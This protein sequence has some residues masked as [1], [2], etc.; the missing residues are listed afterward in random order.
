MR[1]HG[2]KAKSSTQNA[3]LVILHTYTYNHESGSIVFM[4]C[5]IVYCSHIF[6][7][8]VR[9]WGLFPHIVT[10]VRHAFLKEREWKENWKTDFTQN[11]N[12]I[13]SQQ[14]AGYILWQQDPICVRLTR[15]IYHYGCCHG[16][17]HGWHAHPFNLSPNVLGILTSM[18]SSLQTFHVCF[19]NPPVAT[20]LYLHSSAHSFLSSPIIKNSRK[21]T[22]AATQQKKVEYIHVYKMYISKSFNVCNSC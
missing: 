20:L 2:Q 11:P 18:A 12:L 6:F 9:C 14:T 13:L 1:E 22:S 19:Q 15:V 16:K 21:K 5:H 4:K 7:F 3:C 17:C 10:S 8:L